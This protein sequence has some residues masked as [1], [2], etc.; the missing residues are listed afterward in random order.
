MTFKLKL[1][2]TLEPNRSRMRVEIISDISKFLPLTKPK[3]QK[4]EP[5]LNQ[6][7]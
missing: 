3:N 2:K 5:E 4:I 6:S 1:T 7:F